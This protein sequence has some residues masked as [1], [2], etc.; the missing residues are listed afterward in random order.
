MKY[1]IFFCIRLT[2]EH[3]MSKIVR[4]LKK[5]N[6]WLQIDFSSL[7]MIFEKWFK[8]ICIP[9]YYVTKM[10]EQQVLVT[11]HCTATL[12][13]N[14]TVALLPGLHRS[15]LSL[16]LKGCIVENGVEAEIYVFYGY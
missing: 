4:K 8:V 13:L 1:G 14:C 6:V 5:S 2:C 10:C 15:T 12:Q 16:N 7:L 3:H 9:W 11:P